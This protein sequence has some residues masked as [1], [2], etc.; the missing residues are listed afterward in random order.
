MVRRQWSFLIKK[1]LIV[2]WSYHTVQHQGT[3]PGRLSHDEYRKGHGDSGHCRSPLWMR[4]VRTTLDAWKL[5]K[6]TKVS[7]NTATDHRRSSSPPKLVVLETS[8][9]ES[10]PAPQTRPPSSRST[11]ITAPWRW[12]HIAVPWLRGWPR[13]PLGSSW[14]PT[15]SR[16]LRSGKA[17]THWM[18]RKSRKKKKKKTAFEEWWSMVKYG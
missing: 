7:C 16:P 13:G 5:L 3:Q 17:S 10:D 8:A 12:S 6:F 11:V 14:E 4:E 15:V 9:K 18:M 1:N 2:P